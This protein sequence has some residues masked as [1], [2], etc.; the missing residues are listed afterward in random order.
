M[1]KL[2]REQL[3]E[4]S[5]ISDTNKEKTQKKDVIAIDFDGVIHSYKSG[6][7]GETPKDPPMNGVEEALQK[8]IDKGYILKIL[9]TRSPE[10][11]QE[12]LD[13]HNLAKYIS[14]VYNTKI[15]AKI[16]LDDRGVHFSGWEQAIKDIDKFKVG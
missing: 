16:Y 3:D 8:L 1:T 15:R 4:E 2:V 6:W 13:K 9:S 7:T 11:I 5:Q 10:K 12:Y 14:G